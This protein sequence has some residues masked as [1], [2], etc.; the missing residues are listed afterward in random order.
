[1]RS[2]RHALQP[3]ERDPAHRQAAGYTLIELLTVV[4]IVALIA[5]IAIP[6][7]ISQR[8]AAWR[9]STA[10]DV[11]STAMIIE[12]AA[13]ADLP[14]ALAQDGRAVQVLAEPR[15]GSDAAVV[16]AST[17]NE[18]RVVAETH[19][20]PGV[21]LTLERGS[22]THFCLC[23]YHE[24]LGLQPEAIYDSSRGSL[25]DACELPDG[26][27]AALPDPQGPGGSPVAFLG[28]TFNEDTGQWERTGGHFAQTMIDGE[29]MSSGSL[30]LT[31]VQAAFGH[32]TRGGWALA[33]G[34]YGS[35]GQL[36]DGYTVQFDRHLNQF[37]ISTWSGGSE[38][39][40]SNR[41]SAS[42][43]PG[44]AWD[45]ASDVQLDVHN[46][47]LTLLVDGQQMITH[48]L[49]EGM[50]GSL[51]IRT[52]HETSLSYESASLHIND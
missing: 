50:V 31:G 48:Q 18:L 32:D 34:S 12:T 49:P 37:V 27:C 36:S 15:S 42:P 2:D 3:S 46:G 43:P 40:L 24:R 33:Y 47:Q 44:F 30:I 19:S 11:R 28:V 4:L 8:Q 38:Q 5:A 22:D 7:V 23:G 39:S 6:M 1:M 35:N 13:P 14:V 29:P 21:L 9:S 51:G 25:V 20:S 41:P 17:S 26:G 52:W 45:A 10:S 16:M